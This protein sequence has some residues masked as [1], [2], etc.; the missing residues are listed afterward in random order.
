MIAG[1]EIRNIESLSYTFA[2]A[3]TEAREVTLIASRKTKIG[4]QIGLL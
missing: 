4:E 2:V 1:R 3:S